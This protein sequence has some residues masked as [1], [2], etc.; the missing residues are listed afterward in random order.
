[1]IDF[2][3]AAIL[4]VLARHSVAYVLIGGYAVLVASLDDIIASKE[5][6]GRDKDFRALPRLLQLRQQKNRSSG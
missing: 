6:A 5:A 4:K 2:N 1:M 3:P